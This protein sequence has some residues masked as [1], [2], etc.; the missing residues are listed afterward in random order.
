MCSLPPNQFFA[1]SRSVDLLLEFG[2][3]V[4][5][6]KNLEREW[7]LFRATLVRFDVRKGN[8]PFAPMRLSSWDPLLV[9]PSL[10]GM[11]RRCFA[12][13]SRPSCCTFR[14][15]P[16]AHHPSHAFAFPHFLPSNAFHH[17][18]PHVSNPLATMLSILQHV[19]GFHPSIECIQFHTSIRSLRTS[20]MRRE[21][22]LRT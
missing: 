5:K 4:V 20:W 1:A 18:R 22:M 19:L 14:M 3:R 6:E 12:H 9:V 11:K 7:W 21:L 10:N 13:M 8:S 2:V 16:I 17:G 15:E